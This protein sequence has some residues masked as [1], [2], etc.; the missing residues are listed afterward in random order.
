M[1]VQSGTALTMANTNATNVIGQEPL[2]CY[3]PAF[4][5]AH[6]LQAFFCT[7][8]SFSRHP[9]LT[10]RYEIGRKRDTLGSLKSLRGREVSAVVVTA[11]SAEH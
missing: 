11:G 5:Y 2:C 4:A 3:R 10:L 7:A 6:T 8:G 9:T 1:T